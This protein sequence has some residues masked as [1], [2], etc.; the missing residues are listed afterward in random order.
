[1]A[2]EQVG[3]L[4][5]A[6]AEG[7]GD[8]SLRDEA[9]LFLRGL[10]GRNLGLALVLS[11]GAL[12]LFLGNATFGYVS[13]PSLFAWTVNAFQSGDEDGLGLFVPL[14]V[15]VLAW[16][17]RDELVSIPK[18]PS[19]LGA[20]IFVFGLL[21]HVAGYVFQ[22]PKISILAFII[23]LFGIM[24]MLWGRRWMK[25]VFFPYWLLVFCVPLGQQGEIITVPLR[26]GVSALAVGFC[27]SVLG[28]DV[29]RSGSIIY[30]GARTFQ[31][32]VA[33]ACSGIRSLTALGFIISVFAFVQYR[34]WLKRGA[35]MFSVL[36]LAV[37]GNTARIAAVIVVGEMWGQEAGKKIETNLG[38]LTFLVALGGAFGLAWWMD[39]RK[40]PIV[41]S[42]S[43]GGPEPKEER[44]P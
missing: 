44:Q 29:V 19:I 5:D 33:P 38:F 11:W 34:S 36:P 23:G 40:A 25:S 10:P 43:D 14:V 20:G 15:L 2:P 28:I 13:T 37:L 6:K 16:W 39:R 22:Q 42:S 3:S 4:D 12:F 1:M 18:S 41:E 35:L 9:S 21:L 26:M 7:Q 8:L 24:G 31:Y 17:Q 30:N 32:D 27:H